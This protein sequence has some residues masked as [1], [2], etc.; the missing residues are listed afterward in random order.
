MRTIF[1]RIFREF[2]IYASYDDGGQLVG[3]HVMRHDSSFF[4]NSHLLS[5][6]SEVLDFIKA[7]ME[8]DRFMI[9]AYF[10]S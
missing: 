4:L 8:L 1:F 9:L 6:W 10:Q 7:E 5:S 2:I 3:Y